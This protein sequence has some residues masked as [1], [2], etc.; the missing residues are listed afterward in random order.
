MT[1]RSI[2]DEIDL[3][4][5]AAL[6]DVTL[7]RHRHRPQDAQAVRA[8]IFEL[9]SRGLGDYAISGATGLDVAY[10]RRV[11]GEPRTSDAT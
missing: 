1:R 4:G 2:G 11:L 3:A 5:L 8:A 9:R 6:T 10:V 7:D